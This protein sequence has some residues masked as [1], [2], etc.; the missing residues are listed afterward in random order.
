MIEID[1]TYRL[2]V[3]VNFVDNSINNKNN[4]EQIRIVMIVVDRHFIMHFR[5]SYTLNEIHFINKRE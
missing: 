4:D 5:F 1:V 3:I 2:N